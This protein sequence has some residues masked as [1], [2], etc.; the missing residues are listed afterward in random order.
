MW[1]VSPWIV[2]PDLVIRLDTITA[3]N[4][5]SGPAGGCPLLPGGAVQLVP[6]VTVAGFVSKPLNEAGAPPP[7][8]L[9]SDDHCAP[10]KVTF[11]PTAALLS[12]ITKFPP[13]ATPQKTNVEAEEVLVVGSRSPC[14]AGVGGVFGRGRPAGRGDSQAGGIRRR[15]A[16]GHGAEIAGHG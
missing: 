12:P 13:L 15:A 6:H 8:R 1:T 11:V 2:E 9:F 16:V 5:G 7:V 14:R 4:S 3:M 10:Q